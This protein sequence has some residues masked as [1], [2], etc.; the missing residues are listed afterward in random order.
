[1]QCRTVLQHVAI[2]QRAALRCTVLQRR[3]CAAAC[4]FVSPDI[5]L[6]MTTTVQHV[7]TECNLSHD[8]SVT[9]SVRMA[10]NPMNGRDQRAVQRSVCVISIEIGDLA[11]LI[12]S[13]QPWE[14]SYSRSVRVPEVPR[15]PISAESQSVRAVRYIPSRALH[16]H[17]LRSLTRV[18]MHVRSHAWAAFAFLPLGR[19]ATAL[20]V[21]RLAAA[22][23]DA[24]GRSRRRAGW[25]CGAASSARTRGV[26]R[27]VPCVCRPRLAR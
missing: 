27:A 20:N 16:L 19:W 21:T 5:S 18:R 25:R 17:A 9:H 13:H 6:R 3:G 26:Q 2:C 23:R 10:P 7:A 15:L 11:R 8:H 22:A 12:R 4:R 14:A 24:R 1:M